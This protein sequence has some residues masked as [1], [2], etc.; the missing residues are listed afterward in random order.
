[1]QRRGASHS[2]QFTRCSG[3]NKGFLVSLLVR[4]QSQPVQ[5]AKGALHTAAV[6]H[7][8]QPRHRCSDL[9]ETGERPRLRRALPQQG[10]RPGFAT[11]RRPARRLGG[12]HRPRERREHR[13]RLRRLRRAGAAVRDVAETGAGARD[14]TK[15]SSGTPKPSQT[16]AMLA[17]FAGSVQSSKTTSRSPRRRETRPS[18]LL[19]KR[20]S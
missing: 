9:H 4:G 13:T 12:L 3:D 8:T 18:T 10:R 17:A 5:A 19:R 6:Q 14:V 15:S 7:G 11:A 20:A 16:R 1:M 2:S